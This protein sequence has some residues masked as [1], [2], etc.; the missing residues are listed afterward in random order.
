MQT[1]ICYALQLAPASIAWNSSRH[2]SAGL[3]QAHCLCTHPSSISACSHDSTACMLACFAWHCPTLHAAYLQVATH[4]R[5]R[6]GGQAHCQN[7]LR[8]AALNCG[9]RRRLYLHFWLVKIWSAGPWQPVVCP[10]F[11]F[12]FLHAASSCFPP[13][14]LSLPV[15]MEIVVHARMTACMCNQ[16]AFWPFLRQTLRFDPEPAHLSASAPVQEC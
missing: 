11:F 5:H 4:A 16:A 13:P 14:P 3:H 1:V 6:A 8:L 15:R 12:V 9:G 7:S 2:A 10:L